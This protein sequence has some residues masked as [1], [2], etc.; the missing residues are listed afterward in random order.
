MGQNLVSLNR[1]DNWAHLW[2]PHGCIFMHELIIHYLL[3]L[4]C[5]YSSLQAL[6][7]SSIF[8]INTVQECR[9]E[10][11]S[12]VCCSWADYLKNSYGEEFCSFHEK[13]YLV[14]PLVRKSRSACIDYKL[15][16]IVSQ[17]LF[18]K[19]SQIGHLKN[20]GKDGI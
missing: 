14:A 6:R 1:N 5:C 12:K 13:F 9:R 4:I 16:P 20:S 2:N 10:K 19:E 15:W 8:C 3:H 7:D 17:G 11:F 18:V